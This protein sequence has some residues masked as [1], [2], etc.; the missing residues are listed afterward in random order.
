MASSMGDDAETMPLADGIITAGTSNRLRHELRCTSAAASAIARASNPAAWGF[1]RQPPRSD[2]TR[3][4]SRF[5]PSGWSLTYICAIVDLPQAGGTFN[6]INRAMQPDYER[7]HSGKA[8]DS[9]ERTLLP[10]PRLARLTV[11][12]RRSRSPAFSPAN[13]LTC[14]GSRLLPVDSEQSTDR[15][16]SV[17][18]MD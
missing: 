15:Q 6:K 10:Q 7:T 1:A 11:R 16:V 4:I 2:R 13:A 12:R 8:I 17:T 18:Q 14:R 5:K 3:S 9:G